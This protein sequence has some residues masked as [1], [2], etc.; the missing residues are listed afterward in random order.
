MICEEQLSRNKNHF[1][2]YHK[3]SASEFKGITTREKLAGLRT[4]GMGSL[5]EVLVDIS[6][7]LQ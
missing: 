4:L 6:D 7:D 3:C 2:Y 5:W 1:R